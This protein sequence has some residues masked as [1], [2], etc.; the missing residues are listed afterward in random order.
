MKSTFEYVSSDFI[1][2][3]CIEAIK[4]KLKNWFKIK[5]YYCKP[6]IAE[7]GHF[8]FM[9]FMWSDGIDDYDF[10]DKEDCDLP[11]YKCFLFSG[12]IRKF[13]LGFAKKYSEYRNH[14]NRNNRKGNNKRRKI[15]NYVG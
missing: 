2:N 14:Y 15:N 8:Q 12:A 10:S 11:W 4:A 6:R 3:C 1:S 7:N 9:H 13:P 5:I